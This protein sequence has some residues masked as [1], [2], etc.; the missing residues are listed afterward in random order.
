M[1]SEYLLFDVLLLWGTEL[2]A[3]AACQLRVLIS[4]DTLN[5]DTPS[6]AKIPLLISTTT[7]IK[8]EVTQIGGPSHQ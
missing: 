3:E 6:Q 5:H 4:A 2:V 1:D 8:T 7:E